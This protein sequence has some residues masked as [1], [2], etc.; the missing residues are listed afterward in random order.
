MAAVSNTD[1][2]IYTDEK[3]H[4]PSPTNSSDDDVKKGAHIET[5]H[6]NERVPGHPAYYEKDGLRT[7]G[8]DEDHDHEPP[9]TFKRMM[10]LIA[11]AFLWT[12]SQIPVY[13]LGG[14]PPYIYRDIGG[15][16]RWTWFVLGNLLSLAAVCP[17]VGSLSDL[18]GRRYVALIGAT[19]IVIGMIVC[20]TAHSMNIFISGMVL[21]GVGAGINELTALA[22]TSELAPTAKRGKYVAVLIFTIV[23]F[24]PSVLWAQLIASHSS[25]RYCGLLCAVWAFVGLVMTAT[26]YFPPPRV[27]SLGLSR[28]EIVG[29]ID[30]VGG[31]LSVVGM[32]LLMCGLQWGGYQYSWKTAHVLVPLILGF[33]FLVAFVVWEA[34]FAKYPMFPSRIKQAP[35]TMVLTLIIT[36]ISGANFFSVLL[37]WPT[38]SFNVYGQDPVQV[39]IRGIPIGFSI[40]AGAC[41]VLWLLSVFRG[42]NKSL[43]IISS[44]L[45]TAGTGSLAV[46]R[47]DNLYQIWGLLVLAG[48]G[49]GGIVVPASI[50]TTI[51][52]PD[53]LIATIAALTLAIRAIGGSIGYCTYYN[54]F[55]NKFVPNAEY[56]IGGAMELELNITNIT[57]I[58]EAITLTGASLLAE[59]KLIPGIAGNETAYEIVVGAGQI[60]F[61]ESYK[62]VYLASIAFGAC[63][64][65]AACFL[66]D[67]HQFMDDHV[68]VVM[69]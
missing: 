63:S 57:Y 37:F 62:Y 14:V 8:D 50:I 12:G 7:Y 18:M 60:A 40:L 59:L 56:Y 17:F 2:P 58:T 9:M 69:H 10:S 66:G 20:S 22:V 1:R 55:V 39:G 35:R 16:D 19:L 26:F 31:F 46:A 67:I 25:W 21:A 5:M 34:K 68:A 41:I 65:V 42:H 15:A 33:V 6:T 38:Q 13:I 61:A 24:C 43:M 11:M 3:M 47:V 51:I 45:M 29:Q 54:V 48:L 49:I 23:P 36:F 4:A 28:R 53:D 32:I 52:C 30:F 64:I 27:N 44:I